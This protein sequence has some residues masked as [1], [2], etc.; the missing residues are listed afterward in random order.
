MI[1]IDYI[2]GTDK[3]SVTIQGSNFQQYLNII[4]GVCSSKWNKKKY[5][6]EVSFYDYEV[7][8][9]ECKIYNLNEIEESNIFKCFWIHFKTLIEKT[10][11]IAN[12]DCSFIDVNQSLIEPMPHQKVAIEFG[13]F[14]KNFA[15][16]SDAGTGKTL[17]S[18]ITAYKYI[19]LGKA[20]NCLIICPASLCTN[21]INEIKNI[22]GEHIRCI[23]I[24]GNKQKREELYQIES[25]FKIMTYEK[26]RSDGIKEEIVIDKSTGDFKKKKKVD[27]E[28][29]STKQFDII[30]ADEVHRIKNPKAQQTKILHALSKK[31][32]YTMGISGTMI[33]N[34]LID[35]FSIAEFLK[36]DIF[37]G[38]WNFVKRYCV[39]GFFG[40]I[41]GYQNLEELHKKIKTFT[42]RKKRNEVLKD[43]P[44][45]IYKP[46]YVEL[47]SIQKQLYNE[48]KNKVIYN[49]EG[50]KIYQDTLVKFTYMREICN[51]PVLIGYDENY[52]SPKIIELKNILNNL[53]KDS[54]VIIYSQWSSFIKNIMSN[55]NAKDFVVLTGET[56]NCKRQSIV[57]EFTINEEKKYFL[58][59][60]AGGEG[61]NLQ[62]ASYIILMDL[63]L[64][65]TKIDQ[66]VS[67][68]YRK[69]QKNKVNVIPI[70]TKGTIEDR[71]TEIINLKQNLINGTLNRATNINKKIITDELMKE[72]L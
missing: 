12:K 35:M 45:M 66:I 42:F 60:A 64:N 62:C 24:E 55:L 50:E 22:L 69:G 63:P 9:Q 46:Y 31:A 57:D 23:I 4:K 51:S 10:I 7:L 59:T 28:F 47:D 43:L 52:I 16:G 33:Q 61:L 65:P 44:D 5:Y 67:R 54:K 25:E 2:S 8:I 38:Y 13:L 3:F 6:W 30:I 14:R 11:T 53:P 26:L 71:I 18:I 41:V 40:Q 72:T 37:G 19:K 56:E 49:K 70:L 1:L 58:M 36:L 68:A 15:N 29:L 21:W 32:L 39:K 17:P 20:K 48:M 27:D 34:S